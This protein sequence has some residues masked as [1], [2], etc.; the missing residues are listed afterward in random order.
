MPFYVGPNVYPSNM[1]RPVVL[2]QR[3]LGPAHF[4]DQTDQEKTRTGLLITPRILNRYDAASNLSIKTLIS[5]P[6]KV[7][8]KT[9][10]KL[11][12]DVVRANG[13]TRQ[14]EITRPK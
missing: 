5:Q 12:R 6:N 2:Q 13:P 1:L 8:R 9:R 7:E 11:I 14:N 10:G 4:F 3:L